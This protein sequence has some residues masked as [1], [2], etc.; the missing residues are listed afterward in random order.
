[1]TTDGVTTTRDKWKR[2]H[3]LSGAVLLA[4]FLV[5][6]LGTNASALGG[7]RMYDSVVGS[8]ER[9]S[10]LPLI[11]VFIIVPLLFHM[12]YGVHLVVSKKSAADS[13]IDRYGD[14]RLWVLQRMSAV[15]VLI[16]VLVHLWELRLSRLIFGDSPASLYTILSSHLSGT[17]GWVPWLALLYLFGIAAVTFHFANGL[18][19]AT[20]TLGI[21][22][23]DPAGR[24][25]MRYLTA[26]AGVVL[27][28]IGGLTVISIATG[29]R[30]LPA[31]DADS[32]PCGP[33]T[34]V[35][36]AS[37]SR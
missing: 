17:W 2:L 34:A 33:T 22:G 12:L 18:F 4:L 8:I 10:L 3:T 6:H 29:T 13:E 32:A 35:P 25:R 28:L 19:A 5:E 27:F 31:G 24:K 14:R 21:G 20:A 7:E 16:F 15:V 30:L 36:S 23:Q 1:V 37:P 11:E 9:W 26:G